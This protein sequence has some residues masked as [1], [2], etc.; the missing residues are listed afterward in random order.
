MWSWKRGRAL[1]QRTLTPM[2]LFG[3][4]I[5]WRNLPTP[6]AICEMSEIN[7]DDHPK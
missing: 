1:T 5:C 6:S 2:A 3:L 4:A 7:S